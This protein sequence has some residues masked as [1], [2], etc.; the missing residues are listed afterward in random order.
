V[1]YSLAEA[2]R[3]LVLILRTRRRGR[4]L[5]PRDRR[6]GE[7]FVVL[8]SAGWRLG[9]GGGNS[10]HLRVGKPEENGL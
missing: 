7:D 2:A 8:L 4:L 1:S 9:E 5:H 3:G 10:L 6:G